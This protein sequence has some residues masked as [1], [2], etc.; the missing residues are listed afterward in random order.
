[1]RADFEKPALKYPKVRIIKVIC[2]SHININSL[3]TILSGLHCRITV[4]MVGSFYL[5]PFLYTGFKA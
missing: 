5:N 4:V 3:I 2:G 1:M